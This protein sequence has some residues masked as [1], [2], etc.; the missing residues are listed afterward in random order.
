MPLKFCVL[1]FCS[2]KHQNAY[3]IKLSNVEA[4]RLLTILT[5]FHQ[6]GC[7]WQLAHATSRMLSCGY[8]LAIEV[9]TTSYLVIL[10]TTKWHVTS[11]T[12]QGKSAGMKK[13]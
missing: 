2:Y 10:N 7:G 13:T 1:D 11:G 8:C 9:T 3:Y 6:I 4:K 12:G 5:F